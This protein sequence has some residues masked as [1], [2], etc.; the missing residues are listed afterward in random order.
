MRARTRTMVK[1]AERR[2][3]FFCSRAGELTRRSI[4]V[5]L[6]GFGGI[7]WGQRIQAL[8]YRWPCN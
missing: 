6:R 7:F 5:V 4:S 2:E 3:I 8:E 1:S